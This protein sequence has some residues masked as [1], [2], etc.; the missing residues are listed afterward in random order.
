MRFLS[1][2]NDREEQPRNVDLSSSVC[3]LLFSVSYIHSNMQFN[4]GCR[5]QISLQR[6]YRYTIAMN[7]SYSLRKRLNLTRW[8]RRMLDRFEPWRFK[9]KTWT[10]IIACNN[11]ESTYTLGMFLIPGANRVRSS[12]SAAIDHFDVHQGTHILQVSA[13]LHFSLHSN[14]VKSNIENYNKKNK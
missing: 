12:A 2:M 11:A 14:R 9:W 7:L 13:I 1:E 10:F 8:K 5:I 3:S 4:A 6:A